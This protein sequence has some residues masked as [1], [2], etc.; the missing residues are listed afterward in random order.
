M[1]ASRFERLKVESYELPDSVVSR[2][3]S[4]ALVIYLDRV[5]ENLRRVIGHGRGDAERWRPHIKSVKIAE[6]L[7][8]MTRVGLRQFKCATTREATELLGVLD[9]QGIRGGDLLLA[10]P[11]VGPGLERLSRLARAHG[12]A[13]VSVLCEDPRFVDGIDERV[14]IFVDVN[15][16]MNRT[17]VPLARPDV[18][19]EVARRAGVRFRGLHF[20]DGHVHGADASERRRMAFEGYDRLIDLVGMLQ[21][22]GLQVGEIV[23]SGT[24]SFLYALEYSPFADLPG[25]VHRVSPG[26]VV[27]HDLRY[28][29]E[30]EDLDLVPAAMVFSRVVSHPAE[31][32]IT[33]DAGSKSIA[34]E[35]GDPCAFVLGHPELE[36]L[37]PSEEHLPLRVREG[38]CPERG[39]S[40]LLI[41]RHVCPTV[42]L[43][44]QALLVEPGGVSDVVPVGARAHDLFS[45][46]DPV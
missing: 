38:R 22:G 3:L 30:I 36:A 25:T 16:G 8:E 39:E 42:N 46:A 45:D 7:A 20:Y 26:T 27:Y 2:L 32:T 18:V 6:V 19:C 24:P 40:L 15:P 12:S 13:R 4:P 37:Q 33:C 23:T 1:N 14:S 43:A 41:P 28:E 10:Y 29:Q 9:R 31:H 21:R 44:E 34:A 17:G 35:A 5:R 11:L